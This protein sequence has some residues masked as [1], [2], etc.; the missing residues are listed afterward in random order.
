MQVFDEV[1]QIPRG[2]RIISALWIAFFNAA[3]ATAVFFA[4]I[5]PMELEPCIPDF[6]EASRIG[7]YTVGFLLFWLLT[8]ATSL[9]TI[10]FLY[11]GKRS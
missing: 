6:P 4:L 7:A 11:P 1:K 3:V 5:D 2:Q 10:I 8:A 9:F